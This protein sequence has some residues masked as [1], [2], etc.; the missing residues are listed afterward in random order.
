MNFRIL[1]FLVIVLLKTIFLALQTLSQ[2]GP[3][4]LISFLTL[5]FHFWF[6]RNMQMLPSDRPVPKSSELGLSRVN[7]KNISCQSLRSY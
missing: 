2:L 6:L 4:H 7:Q 3:G 5:D 1:F